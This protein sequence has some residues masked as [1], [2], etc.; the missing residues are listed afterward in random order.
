MKKY[1]I[2]LLLLTG[3]VSADIVT[4]VK[5]IGASINEKG[6]KI[7]EQGG[8]WYQIKHRFLK[9]YGKETHHVTINKDSTINKIERRGEYGTDKKSLSKVDSQRRKLKKVIS[10]FER[11]DKGVPKSLRKETDDFKYTGLVPYHN[12]KLKIEFGKSG[13]NMLTVVD[14]GGGKLVKKVKKKKQPKYIVKKNGARQFNR[15]Q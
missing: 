7:V 9:S 5:F 13:G 6:V 8:N 15:L 3:S 1:M 11:S 10:Y 14:S 4:M 2:I 12:L